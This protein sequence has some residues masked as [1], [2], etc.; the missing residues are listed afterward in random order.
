MRATDVIE[1]LDEA[2]AITGVDQIQINHR[3]RLLS[4]NGSAYVSGELR[5]YLDER[6]MTHARGAPYHPQTQ[7]KIE[8]PP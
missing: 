6:K 3:P 5:D 2:L 7:S 8:R 4:E 1:T